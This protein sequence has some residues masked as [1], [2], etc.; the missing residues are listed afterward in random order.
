MKKIIYI[1]FPFYSVSAFAQTVIGSVN[2]G[3]ISNNNFAFSVGEI[4]VLP[5]NKDQTNSGTLG[6]LNQL[7]L[8]V[9]GI[10]NS[11]ASDDFRAFPN[12]V[13]NTLSFKLNSEQ[14]IEQIFIYDLSGKLV[15]TNNI[16]G[17]SVD[18][19]FLNDGAYIIKTNIASITPFKIIKK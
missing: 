8:I 5:T 14:A 13:T 12:P 3:A 6:V 11:I 1:L 15:S 9:T 16:T 2:S 17:N 7:T 10:H 4:F 18:L 19:S